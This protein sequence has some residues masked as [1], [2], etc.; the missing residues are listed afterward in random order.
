VVRVLAAHGAGL[1]L[2]GRGAR[3]EDPLQSS[4]FVD[5]DF[6]DAW[7]TYDLRKPGDGVFVG[8]NSLDYAGDVIKLF[9]NKFRVDINVPHL[10]SPTQITGSNIKRSLFLV[11]LEEGGQLRLLG[12]MDKAHSVH[13]YRLTEASHEMLLSGRTLMDTAHEERVTA[14]LAPLYFSKRMDCS[15]V[16]RFAKMMRHPRDVFL[17]HLEDGLG[18]GFPLDILISLNDPG[19]VSPTLGDAERSMA[20]PPPTTMATPAPEPRRRRN[21]MRRGSFGANELNSAELQAFVSSL[22]DAK[23]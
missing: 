22:S 15:L 20:S 5:G 19:N 10:C 16:L 1:R 13:L 8:D 6:F 18:S 2:G 3:G 9:K 17:L 21:S 11:K 23:A 4:C 14:P 12:L 7:Q